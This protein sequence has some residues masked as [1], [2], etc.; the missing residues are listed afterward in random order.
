MDRGAWQAI[1]HGVA[2]LGR[3]ERLTLSLSLNIFSTQQI[4]G[5][6]SI[7]ESDF[8]GLWHLVFAL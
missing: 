5:K 8:S 3:T 7:T 2:E 1:V 6:P 4:K